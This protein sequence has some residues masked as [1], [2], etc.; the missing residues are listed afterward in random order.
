[1]GKRAIALCV[2]GF[3][4]G[5]LMFT[6]FPVQAHHGDDLRRLKNRVATL[7]NQMDRQKKKTRYLTRQ[8][9]YT[10]FVF[11]EQVIS[12]EFCEDGDDALWQETGIADLTFLGCSIGP[13]PDPTST[14]LRRF[15]RFAA[16]RR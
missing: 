16:T 3:L 12:F 10:D 15:K 11:E 1:M 14:K 8:G 7:E 13:Y 4:V 2:A 6:V 5:G 9:F